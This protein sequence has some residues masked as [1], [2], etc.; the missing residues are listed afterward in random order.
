MCSPAGRALLVRRMAC[1][2][3]IPGWCIWAAIPK[4]L[5]L[6]ASVMSGFTTLV[7]G[8]IVNRLES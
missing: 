4:C 5:L 2:T 6:A 1:P 7:L 8:F 3:Y